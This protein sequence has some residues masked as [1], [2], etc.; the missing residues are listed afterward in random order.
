MAVSLISATRKAE[1]LVPIPNLRGSMSAAYGNRIQRRPLPAQM[2]PT[3]AHRS[4]PMARGPRCLHRRQWPAVRDPTALELA[5]VPSI[6]GHK[7]LFLN[8]NPRSDARG[9][10]FAETGARAMFLSNIYIYFDMA[11][12][13]PI[14]RH[15]V[16]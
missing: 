12:N 15:I 1:P 6:S 16:P 2:F 8:Q 7:P 11:Y 5:R 13:Y 10:P 3:V 4:P 14:K 9:P